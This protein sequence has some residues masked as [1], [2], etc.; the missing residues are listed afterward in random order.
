MILA[1]ILL[2][3]ILVFGVISAAAA[4][5]ES[6]F[7]ALIFSCVVAMMSFVALCADIYAIANDNGQEVEYR[8]PADH[9]RLFE[10]VTASVDTVYVNGIPT[11]SESRDTV[12]VLVG[13][14]PIVVECHR[15]ERN[16]LKGGRHG[17]EQ[18]R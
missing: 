10:E 16:M 17:R 12:Y 5:K 1:L 15:Y 9:Y 14:E 3:L 11:V 13:V 18:T 7:G 8:F 6:N 2:L 4:A